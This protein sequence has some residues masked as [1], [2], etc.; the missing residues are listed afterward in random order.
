MSTVPTKISGSSIYRPNTN[1]QLK[2]GKGKSPQRGTGAAAEVRPGLEPQSY[3]AMPP[4]PPSA[5]S[6]SSKRPGFR[7]QDGIQQFGVD[8]KDALLSSDD[9]LYS[10]E[11]AIFTTNSL[12]HE[13]SKSFQLA[14]QDDESRALEIERFLSSDVDDVKDPDSFA[15]ALVVKKFRPGLSRQKNFPL[16]NADESLTKAAE[17]AAEVKRFLDDDDEGGSAHPFKVVSARSV[18]RRQAGIRMASDTPALDSQ[19]KEE[20]RSILEHDI[21]ACPTFRF[22]DR[23]PE[24]M[25]AIIGDP[26]LKQLALTFLY[27]ASKSLIQTPSLLPRISPISFEAHVA[28]DIDEFKDS[29]FRASSMEEFESIFTFYTREDREIRSLDSSFS[30]T[31]LRDYVNGD[32][33]TLDAKETLYKDIYEGRRKRSRDAFKAG[34]EGPQDVHISEEEKDRFKDLLMKT[35]ATRDAMCAKVN[36]T[37]AS[38]SSAHTIKNELLLNLEK[39]KRKFETVMSAIVEDEQTLPKPKPLPKPNPKPEPQLNLEPDP[40]PTPKPKRLPPK[41]VHFDEPKER[42]FYKAAPANQWISE[43]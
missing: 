14:I 41:K 25:D 19:R 17:I 24:D 34:I 22:R 33:S 8:K 28:I 3:V 11:P 20:L 21:A 40:K 36:L 35:D 5:V 16:L 27:K 13:M 10:F 32:R 12:K 30:I 23:S 4:M 7:R 37:E 6:A 38:N 15:A 9:S 39:D 43:K 2:A 1:N 26:D 29:L 31:M 18:L 42:F